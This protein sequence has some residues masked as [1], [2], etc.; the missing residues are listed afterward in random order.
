MIGKDAPIKGVPAE[1]RLVSARSLLGS[2]GVFEVDALGVTYV[3]LLF[4]RHEMIEANGV[5]TEAYHP[6]ELLRASGDV[7]R[8]AEVLEIFPELNKET[9]PASR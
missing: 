2:R 6:G 8:R 9:Y 3:H 4:D 5:W 1:D 7:A